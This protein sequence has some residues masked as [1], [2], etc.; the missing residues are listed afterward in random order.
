MLDCHANISNFWYSDRYFYVNWQFEMFKRGTDNVHDTCFKRS[1]L[2]S[3]T[4]ICCKYTSELPHRVT[5]ML[6]QLMSLRVRLAP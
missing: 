5:D 6:F 3:V 1:S 4:Y 2:F